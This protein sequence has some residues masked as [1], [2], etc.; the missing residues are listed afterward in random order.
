MA[1]EGPL[2]KRA[3]TVLTFM[4]IGIGSLIAWPHL[5]TG[6]KVLIFL[7]SGVAGLSIHSGTWTQSSRELRKEQREE[8]RQVYRKARSWVTGG[9]ERVKAKQS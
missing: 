9:G 4:V 5:D 7:F 3:Q 8:R 2:S 6:S 1:E